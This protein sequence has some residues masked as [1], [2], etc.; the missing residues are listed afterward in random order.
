MYGRVPSIAH[1]NPQP[2]TLVSWAKH[3]ETSTRE[4]RD[5]SLVACRTDFAWAAE[6]GRSCAWPPA[7]M[8]PVSARC[9]FPGFPGK[10]ESDCQSMQREPC[11]PPALQCGEPRFCAR[12][13][14]SLG[15]SGQTDRHSLAGEVNGEIR[16]RN[17]GTGGRPIRTSTPVALTFLTFSAA[18]KRRSLMQSTS[19]IASFDLLHWNTW[20]HSR[21]SRE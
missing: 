17:K 19:S 3:D 4:K 2:K 21:P 11:P 14:G 16:G 8:S 1:C 7:R 6:T 20:V 5:D 9:R 18:R 15:M 12:S 13:G 10:G